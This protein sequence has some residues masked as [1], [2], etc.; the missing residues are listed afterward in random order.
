VPDE[1]PLGGG[2]VTAGVV[3]VGE[4]VRRPAGPNSQLVAALLLHLEAVGFDGAPRFLGYDERG[5]E[6]LQFIEGDVPSDCRSSV[7]SDEQLA[8]AARLLRRFH[9]A[10]E[11]S[12]LAGDEEVV[13]HNDFGPWNLVWREGAPVAIVDYD[14]AAPGRRLDDLGYAAWKFLNLGLLELPPADQRRRLH[15]LAAAYGTAADAEL[16]ASIGAAQRRMRALIESADRNTDAL[17]QHMRE[18]AW[19]VQHGAALA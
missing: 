16:V 1:V 15:V 17:A 7:W 12:V 3:R 6:I 19:L 2:W 4:T 8:Q 9:D 14:T 5:R 10:T 18:E 13:C 11:A